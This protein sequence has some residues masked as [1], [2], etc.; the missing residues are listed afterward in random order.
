MSRQQLLDL[1][2]R[3]VERR[4]R[5]AAGLRGIAILTASSLLVTVAIALCLN[6]Y[7]FPLASL[8]W[9]RLVLV[10][11]LSA[12][13][14][15]ALVYPLAG[16]TLRASVRRAERAFPAFEDRLITFAER[17]QSHPGP[18]LE[19][20][21]ADTLAIAEQSHPTRLAPAK[22]LLGLSATTLFSVAILLWVILAQPGYVGYGAALLWTGQKAAPLYDIHVAPGDAALRRNTDELITAQLVGIQP[23]KV[24]LFAKYGSSTRWEP[25]EM[26]PQ[27]GA[28]GFQFLFSSVPED[29][30]YYVIAGPLTTPWSTYPLSQE[31]TSP[32]STPPGPASS[33]LSKRAEEISGPSKAP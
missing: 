6:A 18:F 31:S 5:L 27:Q 3:R 25:V 26:Q 23:G 14:G 32:T 17:E 7:A 1:Y 15:L 19:L 8:P 30:E 20:L 22:I 24:Q 4:L 21:A 2:I 11:L 33:R 9:A 28:P 10:F 16:L 29:V 12:I 13:A